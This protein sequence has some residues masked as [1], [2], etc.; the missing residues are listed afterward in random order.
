[1]PFRRDGEIVARAEPGNLLFLIEANGSGISGLPEVSRA[2]TG[3][4]TGG[5]LYAWMLF[6]SKGNLHV[7]G[8]LAERAVEANEAS[9][10]F[11]GL[12]AG[13]ARV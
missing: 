7:E 1:M 8:I 4:G 10:W 13:A 6:P 9:P 12:L 3:R 11:L 2:K 5:P